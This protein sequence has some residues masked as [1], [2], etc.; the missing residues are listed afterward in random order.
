[1]RITRSKAAPLPCPR[2]GRAM[3]N[4]KSAAKEAAPIHLAMVKTRFGICTM[5]SPENCSAF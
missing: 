1:L 5:I 4:R 3:G 2:N